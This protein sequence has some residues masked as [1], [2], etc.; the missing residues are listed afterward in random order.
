MVPRR[1]GRIPSWGVVGPTLVARLV[2]GCAP[3]FVP[4]GSLDPSFGKGG[5]VAT[6]I[7]GSDS[8]IRAVALQ[9]DGKIVVAGNGRPGCRG[10]VRL[11]TSGVPSELVLARYQG[12]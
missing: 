7:G 8:R 1:M 10:F 3:S 5:I 6:D 12:N 4:A 9:P 2:A 11:R